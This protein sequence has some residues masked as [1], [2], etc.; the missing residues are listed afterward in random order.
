M[1]SL[2]IITELLNVGTS[3]LR[4]VSRQQILQQTARASASEKSMILAQS[5]SAVLRRTLPAL[6]IA[7]MWLLSNGAYLSRYDTTTAAYKA[8]DP[9]IPQEVC[10]AIRGFWNTYTIFVNALQTAF[11]ASVLP[12]TS[13]DTMLEEDIDM[14]GFA[15][16]RRRMTE[17]SAGKT[18]QG[19]SG[20]LAASAAA[21]SALHPNEEQVL[22][23]SDLLADANLLALAEV[24]A[25]FCADLLRSASNADLLLPCY[26]LVR[27]LSRT[28]ISLFARNSSILLHSL[29]VLPNHLLNWKPRL[30]CNMQ[31]QVPTTMIF[32]CL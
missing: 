6:R 10:I 22:R 24:G 9:N 3:E 15:P 13:G 2:A 14:L 12:S 7:S 16:L 32:N 5:V 19:L 27:S 26:R 18:G 8:D 1:H 17:T 31:K 30:H 25:R 4:I 29:G 28:G 23:L 20:A 21:G 11:P